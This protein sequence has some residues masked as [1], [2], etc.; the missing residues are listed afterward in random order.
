MKIRA[1]HCLRI[2][3]QM[4][5]AQAHALARTQSHA[6]VRLPEY[7]L[8]KSVLG[9]DETHWRMMGSDKQR[10]QVWAL[11]ADDGSLL[12]DRGQSLGRNS[13]PCP[14]GP[15]GRGLTIDRVPRSFTPST[16]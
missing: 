11:C 12:S 5:W 9:A 7:L 6:H 13:S 3:S 16:C 1:R 8:Q 10:W 2:D 15:A 4:L 14:A